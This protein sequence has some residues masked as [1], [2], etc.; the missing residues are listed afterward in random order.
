MK[1]NH[2][3]IPGEGMKLLV[4]AGSNAVATN[5]NGWK[6]DGFEIAARIAISMFGNI[7]VT[8]ASSTAGVCRL[9]HMRYVSL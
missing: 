9:S 8:S 4:N 5:L 3:I 2:R 6:S 7:V 1:A